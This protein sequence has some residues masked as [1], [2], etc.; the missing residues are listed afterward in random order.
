MTISHFFHDFRLTEQDVAAFAQRLHETVQREVRDY[1]AIT[2]ASVERDVLRVNRENVLLFFRCLAEDRRPAPR[3]L[4]AFAASAK[5]RLHQGISLEAIF[6]SYRI[7]VRVLWECL[8]EVA[9]QEDLGRLG[10]L[11]LEYADRVST[12]AAEAYVEERQRLARSR[13]E[14]TRLLL[15]RVIHDEVDEA[16]TLFEAKALGFDFSRPHAVLVATC[17]HL[18]LRPAT[19][20]D[21]ALAAAQTRLQAQLPDDPAVLLSSGLVAAVA[22]PRLATAEELVQAALAE[23]LEGPP[24]SAVGVGTAREGIR[25]LAESYREAIRARALGRMLAPARILHRYGDVALFD[26]FKEGQPV[27]TFVEQALG[28]LLALS[29]ERRRRTIETL[30]ALFAS[31][32][33]RKQASFR[34]H[35]HQ[36]TLSNRIRRAEE[37]LGEPLLSGER[38]LRVEL[39][40]QLLPLSSFRRQIL[41]A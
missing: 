18:E 6:R 14:A 33:N 3:E 1:A 10:V 13:Q 26:L 37:L 35:V 16:E 9:P 32:L 28:P 27:D 29:P 20:S 7:G 30:D 24:A 40:L 38:R 31:G 11:A 36:N 21:L 2:S 15:T 4:E 19:T 17:A 12:A 34:L 41:D 8:L 22:A 23:A 25:G 5:A 39:A